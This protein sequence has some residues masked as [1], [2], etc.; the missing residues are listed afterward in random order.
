MP[1]MVPKRFRESLDF[2]GVIFT[3]VEEEF[4]SGRFDQIKLI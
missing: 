3:L 2:D 4:H 1:D